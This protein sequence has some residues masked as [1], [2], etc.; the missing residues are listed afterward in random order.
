[1]MQVVCDIE[2]PMNG[3]SWHAAVTYLLDRIDRIEREVADLRG[4]S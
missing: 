4:E 1:M 3:M 2:S